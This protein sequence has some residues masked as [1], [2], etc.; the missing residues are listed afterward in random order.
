MHWT[1][2]ISQRNN[3]TDVRGT[4]PDT[5]QRKKFPEKNNNQRDATDRGWYKINGKLWGIINTNFE[6]RR[7]KC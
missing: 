7:R 5:E 4:N 3:G 1:T 6:F 2:V